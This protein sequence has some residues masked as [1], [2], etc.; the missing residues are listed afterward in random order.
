NAEWIADLARHGLV[1]PSFLPP[2]EI[3]VLR[4]LV[5]HRRTVAGLLAAERN[6]TLKLELPRF[7]YCWPFGMPVSCGGREQRSEP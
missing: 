5:R 3:R 7:G 6:R 1:K 2:P 4:D